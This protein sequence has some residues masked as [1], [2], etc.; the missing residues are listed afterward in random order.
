VVLFEKVGEMWLVK[1]YATFDGHINTTHMTVINSH[2]R[3]SLFSSGPMVTFPGT[4]HHCHL[5][6]T[7]DL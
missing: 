4:Q 7:R 3:L 2:G 6:T 5:A 1:I